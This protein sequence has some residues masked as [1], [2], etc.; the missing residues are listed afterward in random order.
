MEV[1]EL[2][3]LVK[4]AQK[5]CVTRNGRFELDSLELYLRCLSDLEKF[6][7]DERNRLTTQFQELSDEDREYL[8]DRVM[9]RTHPAKFHLTDSDSE[10]LT[11]ARKELSFHERAQLSAVWRAWD[12]IAWLDIGEVFD[13][14]IEIDD[15]SSPDRERRPYAHVFFS[16]GY[17]RRVETVD[18]FAS[19]ERDASAIGHPIIVAAIQHWQK[20]LYSKQIHTVPNREDDNPVTKYFRE[21]FTRRHIAVAEANIKALSMKLATGAL[22]TGISAKMGLAFNVQELGLNEGKLLHDVWREF[23]GW[24][25]PDVEDENEIK[26]FRQKLHGMANKSLINQR[27]TDPDIVFRFLTETADDGGYKYFDAAKKRPTWPSFKN[28]FT[29]WYFLKRVNTIK[30]CP[31]DAKKNP[32]DTKNVTQSFFLP[33]E[34]RFAQMLSSMLATPLVFARDPKQIRET[35]GHLHIEEAILEAESVT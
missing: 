34:K 18:I 30:N 16:D 7:Q 26:N 8:R 21:K 6:S 3:E 31:S 10:K 17:I 13:A 1:D 25:I 32:I 28:A 5:A 22:E 12:G 20:V 23:R 27:D 24:G 15:Q 14:R 19:V 35:G 11:N 9:N 29:A 2:A 4:I 33:P